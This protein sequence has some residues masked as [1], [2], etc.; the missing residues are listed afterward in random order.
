MSPRSPPD[1]VSQR[2]TR[3]SP[4]NRDIPFCLAVPLNRAAGPCF[5]NQTGILNAFVKCALKGWGVPKVVPLSKYCQLIR[6]P[7]YKVEFRP[8]PNPVVPQLNHFSP[9]VLWNINP[10]GM[11]LLFFTFP[12]PC[13]MMELLQR[14]PTNERTSLKSEQCVDIT[15][16]LHIG[17]LYL[18]FG[19]IN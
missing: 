7:Q 18:A 4:G 19:L 9:L 5:S 1:E 2:R 10:C 3:R 17:Y 14:K 11:P 8:P 16:L 6:N 12:I 15:K 13:I